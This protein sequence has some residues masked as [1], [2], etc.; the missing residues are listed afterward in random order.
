MISLFKNYISD[1]E[2]STLYDLDKWTNLDLPYDSYD[3]F[4]FDVPENDE[5]LGI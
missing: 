5:C 1:E 2:F 4:D 3:H